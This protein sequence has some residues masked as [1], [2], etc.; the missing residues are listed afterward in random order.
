MPKD[1]DWNYWWTM[2]EGENGRW[3]AAPG[4]HFVNRIGYIN[5]LHKWTDEQ[6]DYL[7]H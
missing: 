1:V 7:Y 2:V 6:R 5:T 3:Y 4:F